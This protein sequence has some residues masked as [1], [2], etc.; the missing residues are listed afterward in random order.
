MKKL[1]VAK[2]DTLKQEDLKG[3]MENFLQVRC[4][5]DWTFGS[6]EWEKKLNISMWRI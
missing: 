5:F 6:R 4:T 1:E 2:D 3:Q